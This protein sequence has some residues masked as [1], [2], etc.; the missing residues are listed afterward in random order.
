MAKL[1]LVWV[2]QSDAGKTSDFACIYPPTCYN[3]YVDEKREEV[4]D[5][6]AQLEDFV[7]TVAR[8]I[9]AEKCGLVKD[10]YGERLPDDIWQQAIPEARRLLL[11]EQG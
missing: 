10:P 11:I 8:R 1:M 6:L 3:V 4:M 5:I 9:A 2:R 7:E